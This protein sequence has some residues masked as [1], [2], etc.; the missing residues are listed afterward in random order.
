MIQRS[1]RAMM[2]GWGSCQVFAVVKAPAGFP[3]PQPR[4]RER[5]QRIVKGGIRCHLGAAL[6]ARPY[7]R[8][9]H[10]RSAD[11]MAVPGSIHE[12]AFEVA[13][14]VGGAALGAGVDAHLEHTT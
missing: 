10:Q 1:A 14:I 5:A 8:R 2:T 7:F 4:M 9:C 13:D 3:I 11:A 12:P 6:R